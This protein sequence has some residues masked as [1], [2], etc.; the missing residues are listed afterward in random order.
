MDNLFAPFAENSDFFTIS[1]ALAFSP[2]FNRDQYHEHQEDETI[3][4]ARKSPWQ[5]IRLFTKD[6]SSCLQFD[7]LLFGVDGQQPS[8]E[9]TKL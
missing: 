8:L 2:A 9:P 3:F 4:F 1:D 6:I 7:L 5:I